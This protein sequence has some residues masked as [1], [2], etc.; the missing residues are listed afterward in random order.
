MHTNTHR[1]RPLTG[2]HRAS[3]VAFWSLLASTSCCCSPR[4][5]RCW[6]QGALSGSAGSDH[7]PLLQ[8]TCPKQIITVN[9][10][11]TNNH[12][13][14]VQNTSLWMFAISEVSAN[15]SNDIFAVSECFSGL[16]MAGFHIWS[17]TNNNKKR[18]R[19][20]KWRPV[21]FT[22]KSL[23]ILQPNSLGFM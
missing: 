18:R 21:F 11:K 2:W 20:R 4:C 1:G 5:S 19:R 16:L 14:P 22:F 12:S 9:L 7:E 6:G 8:W 13:E 17:Q 3:W 23:R 15:S 10:S